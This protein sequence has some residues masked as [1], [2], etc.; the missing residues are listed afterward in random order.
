MEHRVTSL[1]PAYQL[2]AA[3]LLSLAIAVGILLSLSTERWGVTRIIVTVVLVPPLMFLGP[4]ALS[5][6]TSAL[7]DLLRQLRWWH[8][9]WLLLFLSD[10]VFR[11]RGAE[12]IERTP[13][14]AWALYRIILVGIT[15]LLLVIRV[16][17]TRTS[18]TSLL[19]RGITGWLVAYAL[20]SLLSTS[21][22]VFP[23]WTA[24][25]S[26]EYLVDIT[27]LAAVLA[28]ISSWSQ[29]KSMVDWTIVLNTLL[30]SLAW[31]EALIWP[32]AALIP[33][34]GLIPVQLECIYPAVAANG[35]GEV[36][37]ILA[38]FSLGRLVSPS[39]EPCKFSLYV[40]G[41]LLGFATILFSQ[42]RSAVLGF[43][44]GVGIVVLI[45]QR[46]KAV[47]L[48]LLGILAL[49]SLNG[50]QTLFK[51]Y[52]R[53][54]QSDDNVSTLSGRLNWWEFGFHEFLKRPLTG[55]G[56]YT[57][58][59][60]ILAKIGE[61]D[62][63]SMHNSYIEI[64]LGTSIWGLIPVLVAL[65]WTWTVLVKFLVRSHTRGLDRCLAIDCIGILSVVT[66]RS[67]FTTHLI[68]HPSLV[69]LLAV[70]C[71]QLMRQQSLLR[72]STLQKLTARTGI[73]RYA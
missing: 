28:S 13:V 60:Q 23:T 64:L 42:T 19:F 36:G 73:S 65:L 71:S 30:I 62:T 66:V 8:Y 45:S 58:R 24:Y 16:W 69:F 22:S 5:Q 43:I 53:R 44:L 63:S 29:F 50:V 61:S 32:T 52:M 41:F 6:A 59:F 67:F 49:S 7:A 57:A 1:A 37:A 51:G 25:K 4:A 12:L 56:A 9:G 15:A 47:F 11:A 33:S 39:A 27:F 68:W 17:I 2:R 34:N 20:L 72:G 54:G 3:A 35:I 40:L 55:Y 18:W 31:L 46:R 48:L 10:L 70:G 26:C 21:W 14:D 38:V